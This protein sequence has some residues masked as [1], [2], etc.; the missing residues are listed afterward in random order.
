[1]SFCLKEKNVFL[2]K[3]IDRLFFHFFKTCFNEKNN[4]TLIVR[5]VV[6][7]MHEY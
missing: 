5:N 1:M 6:C 2:S 4:N 3:K 7:I